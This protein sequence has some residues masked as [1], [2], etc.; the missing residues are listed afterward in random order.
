ML[1]ISNSAFD[2]KINKGKYHYKIKKLINQMAAIWPEILANTN[3]KMEHL[4]FLC[5]C[6]TEI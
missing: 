2:F 5:E 3:F 6:E 4:T 1:I